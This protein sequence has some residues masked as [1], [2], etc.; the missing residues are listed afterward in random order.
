MGA[1]D[2]DRA[3]LRQT[4]RCGLYSVLRAA[5]LA[6]MRVLGL[7]EAGRGPVLGPMAVS[8]VVADAAQMDALIEMGVD[9]SKALSREVRESLAYD[10]QSNFV[11]K[12]RLLQPPALEEN[13]THAELQCFAE[14]ILT[15]RPDQVV[16]DAPVGPR[17]IPGFV[18]QLKRR[19]DYQ[20]DIVAENKADARY[21]VVAAASI[22]AKMA[23]DRAMQALQRQHGDIGWG[24]PGE[25]KTIAF[26]KRCMDNGKFPPC[27]RQ[28]WATVQR[29]KQRSLLE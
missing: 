28:R 3:Q 23:R 10:I 9:D 14:L 12:T 17:A 29:L 20:P 6:R 4:P 1:T 24:Y 16:V 22:V 5:S 2:S 19:L 11:F 18:A 13:L 21:P 25:P 26:L 15:L 27:V 8:A 7:D